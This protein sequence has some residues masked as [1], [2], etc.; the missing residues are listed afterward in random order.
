MS[1]FLKFIV[2][3]YVI[4]EKFEEIILNLD[5]SYIGLK[6]GYKLFL[7]FIG[8]IDIIFGLK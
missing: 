2:I 5:L 8:I 7:I 4:F 1:F 3:K 6:L